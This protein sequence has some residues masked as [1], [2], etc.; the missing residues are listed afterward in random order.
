MKTLNLIDLRLIMAIIGYLFGGAQHLAYF[1]YLVY[2]R[3]AREKG[4]ES[5][6]FGHDGPHRPDV[7]GTAVVGRPQEHFGCPVPGGGNKNDLLVS[8][9]KITCFTDIFS[10]GFYFSENWYM[11]R[12]TVAAKSTFLIRQLVSNFLDFG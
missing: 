11:V 7:D 5:V 12:C 9:E 8:R 10:D 4:S 3:V 2:F 6:D 1:K